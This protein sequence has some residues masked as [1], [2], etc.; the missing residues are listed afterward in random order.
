M[1]L[2]HLQVAARQAGYLANFAANEEQEELQHCTAEALAN[3]AEATT[4][5][6]EAMSNLTETNS[7]LTDH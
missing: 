4:S 5:D 6:R 1:E 3:L 7:A 2:H